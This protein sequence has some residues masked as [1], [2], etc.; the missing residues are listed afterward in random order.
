MAN[1]IP[2]S[3]MA[4]VYGA[5]GNVSIGGL[6]LG[7]I[8]PGVMI[9]IGLM[10]Y[11]YFFGPVGIKKQR[12]TVAELAGALRGSALP[13]MIPLIIMGGIL[14][15]WFTPTE[16]GMIASVYI[17]VVLIPA[18]NRGHLRFLLWDFIYTGMLYA[19]PLAAV[20]GAS[21]FGWMLGYLRGPDVVAAWIGDFAGTNPGM[22]LLLLVL[23]FVVIGDFVDAVPAIIIFMPIINKLTEVGEINSV[24]M[25][26]VIITTLVFGLITP[27]YG[28]SLLVAS[29]FVG[30]SFAKAMYASLPIYVVFLLTIAFTVLFPDIVLYLPKLLLPES[31]GCFKSPAGTGYICPS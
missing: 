4:V 2:P 16:A 3:I 6:F 27:P 26:V 17:L 18:L 25:G 12:A 22:I 9:G 19:I 8:A 21:A 24:H 29:K 10:I 28:L 13:L 30:V 20:A 7:G 15:G 11:A 1:L 23:L 5:T 31:V 14:S